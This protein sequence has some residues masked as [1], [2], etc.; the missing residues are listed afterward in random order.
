MPLPATTRKPLLHRRQL[1]AS[2][3]FRPFFRFFNPKFG[4]ILDF[5]R[6]TAFFLLN[7]QVIERI[8]MIWG[9]F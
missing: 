1:W 7:P 5:V 6:Y 2:K 4:G 3:D 9:F 8:H